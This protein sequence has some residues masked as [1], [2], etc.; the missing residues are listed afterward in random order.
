MPNTNISLWAGYN[1]SIV[2]IN[3]KLCL[4]PHTKPLNSNFKVVDMEKIASLI[5]ERPYESD[6]LQVLEAFVATEFASNNATYSFEANK[7]LIKIYQ[8]FPEHLKA[9]LLANIFEMALIR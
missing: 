5:K 3:S 7:A 6:T 8:A 4:H 1:T 2:S 9:E